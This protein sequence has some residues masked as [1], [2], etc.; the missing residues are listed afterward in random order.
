MKHDVF[1]KFDDLIKEMEL[2][3]DQVKQTLSKAALELNLET[4]DQNRTI[5]ES[6]NTIIQAV[7]S[8]KNSWSDF[9]VSKT[10]SESFSKKESI[11]DRTT[12]EYVNNSIRIITRRPDSTKSAY[13]NVVPE[14]L[15]IKI[16]EVADKFTTQNGYVKTSDIVS[17]L[18]E[19]IYR[20]SDYNSSSSVSIPV[21]ATFRVLHLLGYLTQVSK[22]KYK[23]D[24]DIS[25][26]TIIQIIE[27]KASNKKVTFSEAIKKL[28][29]E[30]QQDMAKGLHEWADK[31]G[32]SQGFDGSII[33][34]NGELHKKFGP[35][36]REIIWPHRFKLN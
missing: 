30:N 21:Y 33:G 15:F 32:N 29:N 31:K 20:N 24:N 3:L 8:S 5:A 22:S 2:E 23:R 9:P 1:T 10:N 13:S 4:L 19:T 12:W 34:E 25:L 17:Y 26:L 28:R 18:E 6:M 35:T 27:S 7:K 11:E 16:A 36:M 14:V